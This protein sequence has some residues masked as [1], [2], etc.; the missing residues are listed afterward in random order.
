ML[1]RKMQSIPREDVLVIPS[2]WLRR[3]ASMVLEQVMQFLD[4]PYTP[5]DSAM[6]TTTS[7]E[8]A[9]KEHFPSKCSLQYSSRLSFVVSI[10]HKPIPIVRLCAVALLVYPRFVCADFAASTGWSASS[11]YE[12]LPEYLH[13]YMTEFME[14]QNRLLFSLLGR[15]FT[16]EW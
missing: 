2:G 3:N 12:P 6:A 4:L 5:Q 9:V 16:G 8:A 1:C 13:Q 10:F 14:P 7:T 15:N 11:V